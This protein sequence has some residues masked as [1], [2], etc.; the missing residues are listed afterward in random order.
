MAN[1]IIQVNNELNNKPMK[2]TAIESDF[3]MVALWEAKNKGTEKLKYSF[4]EVYELSQNKNKNSKQFFHDLCL[5]QK[6]FSYL[7]YSKKDDD[8]YETYPLFIEYKTNRKTKTVE[9]KVNPIMLYI[10][11]DFLG[12]DFTAF[13]MDDYLSLKS[14]YAKDLF[15][16]LKQYRTTGYYI[17]TLEDLRELLNIPKTYIDKEV[18]RSIIK[19][20]V[21]I[22]QKYFTGLN[23]ITKRKK[24]KIT[25]I[26]FRFKQEDNN[27]CEP[28]KPQKK[29]YDDKTKAQKYA[30]VEKKI[31]KAGKKAS[32][33]MLAFRDEIKDELKQMLKKNY[34]DINEIENA[35]IDVGLSIDIFHAEN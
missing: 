16:L 15:R 13:K 27:Y 7:L 35:L 32:T 3:L 19:P 34:I 4:D 12:G 5:T 14:K 9:L 21:K 2:L 18:T 1:E 33:E 29:K 24:R 28:G 26:E 30:D 22:L 25:H 20:S 10:L 6:K 8:S 17:T 11:N 23:Y 31:M